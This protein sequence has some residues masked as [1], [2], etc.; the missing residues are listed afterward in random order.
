MLN[1]CIL[2]RYTKTLPAN[3]MACNARPL[4]AGALSSVTP[5]YRRAGAKRYVACI[6]YGVRQHNAAKQLQ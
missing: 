6:L 1:A 3:K 2:S 5:A 4:C